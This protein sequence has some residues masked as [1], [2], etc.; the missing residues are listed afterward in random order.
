MKNISFNVVYVM[1]VLL[2]CL[3]FGGCSSIPLKEGGLEIS[4]DTTLGIGDD[5][6]VGSVTRQF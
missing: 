2:V 4:K 5:I 1:S 6:G 3:C